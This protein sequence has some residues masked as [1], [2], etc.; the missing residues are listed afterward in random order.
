[1]TNSNVISLKAVLGEVAKVSLAR[2]QE[3][4]SVRLG[5]S[6]RQER[7]PHA[8]STVLGTGCRRLGNK[9]TAATFIVFEDGTLQLSKAEQFRANAD[10]CERRASHSHDPRVKAQ[11]IDLASHWRH[12]AGLVESLAHDRETAKKTIQTAQ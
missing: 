8:L 5:R 6:I 2:G 10:E 7:A 3:W 1:V 9:E 11:F 12:L 4:H